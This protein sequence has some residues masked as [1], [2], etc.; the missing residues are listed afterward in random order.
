LAEVT[1]RALTPLVEG[2]DQCARQHQQDGS[3]QQSASDSQKRDAHR[4][5]NDRHTQHKAEKSKQRRDN[6]QHRT[7]QSA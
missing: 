2:M 6:P 1:A 4:E 5:K 7:E 3:C